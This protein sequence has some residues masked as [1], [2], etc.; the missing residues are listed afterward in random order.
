MVSTTPSISRLRRLCRVMLKV[1][2]LALLFTRG[3][4]MFFI[5]L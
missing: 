3:K 5:L 2:Y 1:L 4:Y